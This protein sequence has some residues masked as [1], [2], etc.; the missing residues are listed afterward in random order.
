MTESSDSRIRFHELRFVSPPATEARK[1]C[2]RR[3][4][5]GRR[6][7]TPAHNGTERMRQLFRDRD[8]SSSDAIVD[9]ATSDPLASMI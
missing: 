5:S 6:P 3:H 2:L 8:G 9:M 4:R 7:P 1:L